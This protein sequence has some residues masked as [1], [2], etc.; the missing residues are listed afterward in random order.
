MTGTSPL[1][2]SQQGVYALVPF[3]AR[4]AQELMGKSATEALLALDTLLLGCLQPFGYVQGHKT[5]HAA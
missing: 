2:F 3:V 1:V 5:A 4:A